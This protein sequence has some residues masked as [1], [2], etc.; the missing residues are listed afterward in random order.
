MG[1]AQKM[2]SET[3]LCQ[4]LAEYDR[5][6]AHEKTKAEAGDREAL[7]QVIE[8]CARRAAHVTYCAVMETAGVMA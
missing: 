4:Q 1:L 3:T 8:Y 5:L 2:I 7:R 6:I